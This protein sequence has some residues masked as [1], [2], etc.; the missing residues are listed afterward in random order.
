MKIPDLDC[1]SFYVYEHIRN[2]VGAIFYVGKGSKKRAKSS[3]GRN[4]HW[5]N[6]VAKSGGFLVRMVI[7]NAD[8]ELA[9]LVETERI[10]QLERLGTKLCNMTSGGEGVSGYKHTDNARKKMQEI[11][12]NKLVSNDVRKKIG[13]ANKGRK[14]SKEHCEKMSKIFKG[15]I[16]SDEIKQKISNSLIGNKR[17]LGRTYSKKTKEK[18][19]AAHIGKQKT[20]VICPYCLKT[21]GLAAMHRW[22]FNNCNYRKQS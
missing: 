8:E 6:I 14:L 22:H 20:K 10:D 13:N 15:K 18:M 3:I 5:Q 21:G 19:S 7:E 2:D 12:K 9:F 1:S 11:H 17:S 16:V 4:R